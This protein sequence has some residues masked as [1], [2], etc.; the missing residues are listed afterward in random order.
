MRGGFQLA[1]L[2]VLYL[3]RV[4]P[5]RPA[6]GGEIAYSR[7]VIESMREA[8]HLTVLAATNGKHATGTFQEHGVMWR[9]VRE[10]QRL[11]SLSLLTDMPNI[12]WKNATPA[13]RQATVELLKQR[14]DAVIVDHI[15][16]V[17]VLPVVD[18]W[19][20]RTPNGCLIY[21][22]HEH[23]RTTRTEKYASYVGGPAKL[24][25]MRVDGWKI[26][27]WEDRMVG[28]ADIVSLI[29]PNERALFEAHVPARRYLT[30][31]P[32]YDGPRRESR[33]LDEQTPM[34]IAAI[35][36][37]GPLHKRNIL[38]DWLEACAVPFAEAGIEMDVIGD[39]DSEFRAA[40][41]QRYPS[42]V[43]SGFVEDLDTHLQGVR[44]GVIP[45]TVGRGVKVRLAS[46]IFSRVPMAGIA[47]AIDGLPIEAGHDFVEASDPA[48]LTALCIALVQDLERLN[49]LQNNAFAA[50]DGRFDWRTRG[51]D[52][53]EA[54]REH[55]RNIDVA[56]A[57]R[58]P[59]ATGYEPTAQI[60]RRGA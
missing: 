19:R 18:A 20:R 15:A 39:I 9:L 31:L 3:T 43:F 27:R 37:R 38:R 41:Q 13:Y 42:V 10:T 29:N 51:A 49:T 50:C 54:I 60:Q 52:I 59:V 53:V 30:T 6:F 5:Q 36:G 34:R 4:Y 25:A 48:T 55:R 2:R 14:W 17:H 33:H 46:Y 56:A 8:C 7:G 11:E 32:G 28:A 12:M 47:G 16:S 44:L 35:G 22:S 26:G 57:T 23:E 1:P 24:A 58:Q 45:D 40:L 21:L